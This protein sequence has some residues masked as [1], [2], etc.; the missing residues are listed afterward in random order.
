MIPRV[1]YYLELNCRGLSKIGPKC[2]NLFSVF[3]TESK[4]SISDYQT[5]LWNQMGTLYY[6]L[7]T[8]YATTNSCHVPCHGRNILC[9]NTFRRKNLFQLIF[10]RKCIVNCLFVINAL[11]VCVYFPLK[12]FK[13][14]INIKKTDVFF[15]WETIFKY[16]SSQVRHICTEIEPEFLSLKWILICVQWVILNYMLA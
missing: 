11:Y 6:W 16:L 5:I 2:F 7:S 10:C 12:N 13:E 14:L 15:F 3:G 9:P 4:F 1:L 8:N